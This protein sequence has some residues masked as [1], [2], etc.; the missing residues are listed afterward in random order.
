MKLTICIVNSGGKKCLSRS[1]SE[2]V[3]NVAKELDS[4][5]LFPFYREV[6]IRNALHLEGRV[7]VF[8]K[9]KA[10]NVL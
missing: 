7:L 8:F 5:L 4:M 10:K 3:Q 2:A 6:T 1:S 9:I